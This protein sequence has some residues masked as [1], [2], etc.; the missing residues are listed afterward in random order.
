MRS[1][2][3]TG[4]KGQRHRE[5]KM[6]TKTQEKPNEAGAWYDV[7]RAN[8][9]VD[10]Y[11]RGGGSAQPADPFVAQSI[12]PA[13]T[14]ALRDFSYIAPEL[15]EFRQQNCVGCMDCVNNCPDTAILAR[16]VK[17][18]ALESALA[19]V[20]DE[21]E[22]EYIKHE[23][24]ITT[25]Y[26]D[27][28]EKKHAK[29][30]SLPEG[31]YFSIYIDP[32]KCKGC[33]ECVEACGE[34]FALKMIKKTKDNLPH[35]INIF[36]FER[37]LP[38]TPDE[39]VNPKIPV[40]MMLRE[41]NMC[42]YAGGAGSCM[43][44][45]EASVLR[46]MLAATGEKVGNNFGIVAATGC[47][48]VYGSTYP[49]NPYNVPWT[50]SLFENAPADAMGIRSY[51]DTHGHE[52]WALW[53]LGGDGAMYDIGF[54]SLSRM[55]SS[56][57]NIKVFVLDTQVYSNTGGQTSTAS[58][59]GQES[60]MSAYGKIVKG[61]PERRKELSLIAMMHPNTYVSQTVGPM[62]GHFY[63]SIARALDYKGPAVIVVYTTCQPEH[64]VADNMAA[65]QARL[66]VESRAFPIFTY[67]PERGTTIR[68]HLSL[69]GNP[70]VDKNWHARMT[71]EGKSEVINFVSFA[72]TEGRFKKHFDR[73]GNPSEMI[74][75]AQQERLENWWKL[76]ELAGIINKDRQEE[77]QEKT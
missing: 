35:Y 13:S 36:D 63:K 14:G 65:H 28:Y 41:K 57:M 16:V 5:N 7:K 4:T 75:R 72:K 64:G 55:L 45:G 15:P 58:F 54:Q 3:K 66:S 37:K 2:Y 47:N 49:Y 23:F 33:G 1:L 17:K 62:T 40:D 60:K 12:L 51:W 9:V 52:D 70:S 18:D 32:T 20:N 29:D 10:A 8:E 68:E 30:P 39:Y 11:N 61:K 56:G 77:Q 34:H 73:D 31:A 53:V 27:T 24:A 71:K 21:H 44:C 69:Q 59:M 67:D 25:K 42:L 46:Q 50:N 26:H 19:S 6:T 43:G 22:K 76:Q 38:D 74:L 48:T